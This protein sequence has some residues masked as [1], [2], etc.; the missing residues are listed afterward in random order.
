[1]SGGYLCIY[2]LHLFFLFHIFSSFCCRNTSAGVLSIVS[3]IIAILVALLGIIGA[4][5]LSRILIGLYAVI[6]VIFIVL[7]LVS[8]ILGFVFRDNLESTV[9]DNAEEAIRGYQ[10]STTDRRI[11]DRIQDE[12]ECCGWNNYTDWEEYDIPSSCDCDNDD[13][14]R[15]D[16]DDDGSAGGCIN[17]DGRLVYK[18]G[19][20]DGVVSF[21]ETYQL[22]LGAIGIVFGLIQIAVLVISIVLCLCIHKAREEYTTV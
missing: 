20:Q 19:C 11:I 12:F 5:A 2:Q 22:V 14:D 9:T 21:L 13:D 15:D 8:G 6:I 3:G 10:N 7:E 4:I 18:D 17:V 16:G 1:V